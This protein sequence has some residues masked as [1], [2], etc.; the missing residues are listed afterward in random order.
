M[1]SINNIVRFKQIQD[2]EFRFIGT[3][4]ALLQ[5]EK[6]IRKLATSPLPVVIRGSKGSGKIIAARA[7]H[8]ASHNCK[9]NFIE[10]CCA[11]LQDEPLANLLTELCIRA[12][13]GTIFL[14]NIDKLS[15]PQF[16]IFAEFFADYCK[17]KHR[18]NSHG[19][20]LLV[21][22]AHTLLPTRADI[23]LWLE[24][25]AIELRLPHLSERQE[26]IRDLSL[27]FIGKYNSISALEFS[28]CAWQLLQNFHWP[29][30][31]EQLENM[32]QKLVFMS[33]QTL[34]TAPQLLTIF[35]SLRTSDC[36]EL[37]SVCRVTEIDAI[38]HEDRV[39]PVKALTI[40]HIL[41][42]TL[43]LDREHPALLKAIHFLIEHYTDNISMSE[44]AENACVSPS[45][46]SFLLKQR[47][48]RS[49]KQLITDIRI[50][51]AKYFFQRIPA[52]QITQVCADVGFSDLSHFEKTFKRI[53]GS[54]P[55]IY[56]QQ[57]RK[58]LSMTQ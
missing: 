31:A 44:L 48:G 28:S 57:F 13:D 52:R 45:H 2:D 49:F 7:I 35:P 16:A 22:S 47:L 43:S 18:D 40:E 41:G 20:R 33:E 25:N 38:A 36:N 24:F 5:L 3:S 8:N 56:R 39:M 12:K 19:T 15:A 11:D 26:D 53:T 58:P 4:P 55:S 21:S 51:K 34:F 54:S 9:Q 6:N 17:A 30:G 32:I 23:D 46:L 14:R 10:Y 27:V 50:E 29:N 37:A 42:Q 1:T